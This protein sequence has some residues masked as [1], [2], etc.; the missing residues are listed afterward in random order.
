MNR[1]L[2]LTLFVLVLAVD[3]AAQ[4]VWYVDNDAP[5][6]GDGTTWETAYKYLQDALAATT[7][8]DEIRVAA[9]LY[10]PDQDKGGNVI[11]GERTATFQLKSGVVILGGYAGLANPGDPDARDIEHYRTTLSGD[12]VQDDIVDLASFFAYFSG[13]G[14]PWEPECDE[15]DLDGDDFEPVVDMGAIESNAAIIASLDIMPDVCPNPVYPHTPERFLSVVLA[16]SDLLEVKDV[17]RRSLLLGRADGEGQVMPVPTLDEIRAPLFADLVGPTE[18]CVCSEPH[19]DG[20][21]DLELRFATAEVVEQLEFDAL[22]ANTS[23]RLILYGS[24]S[25]GQSFAASDCV[26][27]QGMSSAPRESRFSP[28]PRNSKRSLGDG[29]R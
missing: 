11:P 29:G 4:T 14:E 17:V 28:R 8:D 21:A 12:L 3:G 13:D 22:P 10:I 2:L 23:V 1:C 6:G 24:L 20:L 15:F 18:P 25:D 7:G 26:L 27:I 9:G 5:A 19:T 16:G